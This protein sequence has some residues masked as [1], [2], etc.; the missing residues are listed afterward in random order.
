MNGLAG[1]RTLA[2]VI[3]H[4]RGAQRQ[5]RSLLQP[6]GYDAVRVTDG[7]AGLEL[8][9]L[10]PASFRLILIE[11]AVRGL[12]GT[13]VLETLQL[14]RPDLPVLCLSAHA[15]G[16]PAGCLRKPMQPDELDAQLAALEAGA[17]SWQT[18]PSSAGAEAINRARARFAQ[19][20]DLV[21]AALELA[22]GL[23]Q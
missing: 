8:I 21:E 14:F 6:R 23:V 15:V 4:D 10:L 5:V 17:P 3:D 22:K 11:L 2:L 9:Q 16:V 19:R 18:L 1:R 13:V 20:N 12:P 7:L